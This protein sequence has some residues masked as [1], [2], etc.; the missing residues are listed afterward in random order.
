M[1]TTP[2][3]FQSL[4]ISVTPSE[5]KTDPKKT[6]EEEEDCCVTPKGK[7]FQIPANIIPATPCA[8]K[9]NMATLEER[10]TPNICFLNQLWMKEKGIWNEHEYQAFYES[11]A[12]TALAFKP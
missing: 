11:L 5:S 10:Y 3:E 1:E 6:E 7:E 4:A 9:I 2:T 8:P 12:S